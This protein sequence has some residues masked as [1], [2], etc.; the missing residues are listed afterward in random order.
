MPV[1]SRMARRRRARLNG[2]RVDTTL[3]ESVKRTLLTMFSLAALC[4]L[5]SFSPAIA[6]S[7]GDVRFGTGLTKDWKLI[8][9]SRELDTNLVAC[10]FYAKKAFGVMKVIVS[11]YYKEK[12]GDVES[13]LARVNIDVNPQW[14]VLFIPELPL[15]GVGLYTFTMAKEDGEIMADGAV[16]ITGKKVERK[17]PEQPKVDGT[18][19]E[20][21]FK[22]FKPS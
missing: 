19:P 17:M 20:G 12:A 13:T 7:P 5:F 16:T 3:E 22:K 1:L 21:L 2:I 6:A 11:I 8:N 18:T 9:E 14:G 10:G 15:P 4:C